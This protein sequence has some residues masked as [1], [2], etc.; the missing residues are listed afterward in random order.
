MNIA[1]N[2]PTPGFDDVDLK[3]K[4]TLFDGFFKINKYTVQHRKFGGEMGGDVE[5]EMF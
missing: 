3:A 1:K 5:S 4:T 2:N